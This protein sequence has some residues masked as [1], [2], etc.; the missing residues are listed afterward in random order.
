M[1][2]PVPS[3]TYDFFDPTT[4]TSADSCTT[5]PQWMRQCPGVQIGATLIPAPNQPLANQSGKNTNER[6]SM[7]SRGSFSAGV[8]GS[9]NDVCGMNRA[10]PSRMES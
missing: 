5:K 1:R 3:Q 4:S 8:V 9:S 6:N 7:L 10:R 2:A